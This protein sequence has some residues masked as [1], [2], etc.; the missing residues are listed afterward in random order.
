MQTALDN[1]S[2]SRTTL[3][4]AHRLSTIKKANKI[5]VMQKG[6]IVES[7]THLDLIDKNGAYA[8]LVKAQEVKSGSNAA[9]SEDQEP[10]EIAETT[11]KSPNVADAADDA[12]LTGKEVVE[13]EID[14]VAIDNKR[15]AA[16]KAPLMRIFKLQRSELHYVFGGILMSACNGALFPLFGLV[17]GQVLAVYAKPRQEMLDGAAFWSLIFL[18]IMVANFFINL[19]QFGLFGSAGERLTRRVREMEFHALLRQE[20]AF[21]DEP[22]HGTGALTAR[23][24]DDATKIQQLTGP[25]MGTILQVCLYSGI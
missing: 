17:F 18:G 16:M 2:K 4:I 1:A 8:A 22:I 13:D 6:E 12:I 14:H 9:V 20:I 10:E 23:L 7:G 25:V 21:F 24:A 3:V 15:L 11:E 19:L 5:V